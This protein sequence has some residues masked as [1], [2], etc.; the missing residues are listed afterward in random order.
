MVRLCSCGFATDDDDWLAGHL[1]DHPE[2]REMDSTNGGR[3][4]FAVDNPR[5]LEALAFAWGDEYDEI[6]VHGGEWC[7][8]HKDGHDENIITG[9][10]PD[11]LNRA[12][13]ADWLR[14]E[15]QR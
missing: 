3:D 2:H 15:G 12:I 11:E 10:T 8:H 5:A 7:A 4:P 9:D 1:I 13:R 6:W 14:R